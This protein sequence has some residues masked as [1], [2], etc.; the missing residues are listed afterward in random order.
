MNVPAGRSYL[1]RIEPRLDELM[2][3]SAVALAELD[4]IVDPLGIAAQPV[5]RQVPPDPHLAPRLVLLAAVMGDQLPREPQIRLRGWPLAQ[6]RLETASIVVEPGQE[7][8][9][10]LLRQAAW[11]AGEQVLEVRRD[12]AEARRE[13]D[14]MEVGRQQRQRELVRG[15]LRQDVSGDDVGHPLGDPV[16]VALVVEREIQL[17]GDALLDQRLD[18]RHFPRQRRRRILC[19][20]RF[21]GSLLELAPEM[22]APPAIPWCTLAT[23]RELVAVAHERTRLPAGEDL[24]HHFQPRFVPQPDRPGEDRRSISRQHLHVFELPVGR[25]RQAQPHRQ[26]AERHRIV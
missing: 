14:I 20:R 2:M 15:E 6:R 12:M 26:Q 7:A 9:D 22:G 16:S 5:A 4:E 25:H 24:L 17:S 13:T 3:A 18:A 19:V 10:L 21:P 8:I 1:L 11:L 23:G